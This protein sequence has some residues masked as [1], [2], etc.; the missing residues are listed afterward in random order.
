MRRSV[1]IL[2]LAFIAGCTSVPFQDTARVSL[3]SLD[4]KSV[5][6]QFKTK[7]PGS[8]QLLSTVVFEYNGRTFPG[9]GTIDLNRT[10]RVFKLA[11]MNA[12]GVKL[13]ELSGDAGSTKTHYALAALTQY[14][15]IGT[16]VGIDIR[17][18][19]F[20]LVPSPDA[21]LW[22]RT[23]QLHYRQFYGPGFL[24]FVFAGAHGDLIA[25]RY[26]EDNQL[27]WEVLYYEYRDQLGK[28]FP[29]GI[30]FINY[31]NG[32]RLTVRQKELYS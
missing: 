18:I 10:D 25:K 28:R 11:C 4:P 7:L 12:M 23:E 9:L 29:Q 5:V 17:R 21:L 13:F 32:Y 6:D 22:R 16:A 24:E 27:A 3:D 14:G 15:D 2:L 30:V 19:Y 1:I 31:Q 20:D 26:Y 8:F